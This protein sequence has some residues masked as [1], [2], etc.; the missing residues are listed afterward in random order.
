MAACGASEIQVVN[1]TGQDVTVEVGSKSVAVPSSWNHALLKA[2]LKA[3]DK[4][5]VKQGERVLEELPLT[6]EHRKQNVVLNVKGAGDFY[7]VEYTKAYVAENQPD[8]KLPDR[9]FEVVAALAGKSLT[10]SPAGVL[11][12]Y[13][14]ALPTKIAHGQRVFRIENVPRSLAT[15]GVDDYLMRSFETDL[16]MRRFIYS[17]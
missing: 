5:V 11:V 10:V 7:L 4:I 14:G 3:G 2:K 16:K 17:P 1:D 13:T 9:P 12:E 6:A 15:R 8:A